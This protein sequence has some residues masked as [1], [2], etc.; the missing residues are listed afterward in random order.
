MAKQLSDYDSEGTVLGQDA[1]D[2][3]GF[4]GVATPIGQPSVTAI[5]TT[6]IS[7][8]GTTG[9][10]AFATSTAAPSSRPARASPRW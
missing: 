6:T 1:D 3:I 10:W 8:V 7:Q 5:G 9:K 4:Y 2:K